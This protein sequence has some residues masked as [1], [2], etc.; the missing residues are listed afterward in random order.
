[1]QDTRRMRET[2]AIHERK[3]YTKNEM[4]IN[5]IFFI[6]EIVV[7]SLSNTHKSQKAIIIAAP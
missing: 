4:K 7:S 1:V 6:N 5:S 2:P 3:K